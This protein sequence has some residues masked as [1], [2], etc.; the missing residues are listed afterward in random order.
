MEKQNAIRTFYEWQRSTLRKE[1]LAK[2]LNE[3]A[4]KFATSYIWHSQEKITINWV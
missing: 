4:G 2:D 1:G 3:E